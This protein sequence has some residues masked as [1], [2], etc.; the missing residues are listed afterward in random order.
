MQ[1]DSF[2]GLSVFLGWCWPS[3]EVASVLDVVLVVDEDWPQECRRVATGDKACEE[4]A[5]QKAT[6]KKGRD[7]KEGKVGRVGDSRWKTECRSTES[8]IRACANH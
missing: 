3:K 4:Q 5:G 2:T 6:E 7:S 8:C 1:E